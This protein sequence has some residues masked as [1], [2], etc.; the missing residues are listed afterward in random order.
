MS[1]ARAS[2]SGALA[3]PAR[4]A[5]S[6]RRT[7]L[8][9]AAALAL[10]LA[11]TELRRVR[12]GRYDALQLHT[13]GTARSERKGQLS[14]LHAASAQARAPELARRILA[15]PHATMAGDWQYPMRHGC[16]PTAGSAVPHATTHRTFPAGTGR[17]VGYLFVCLLGVRPLPSAAQGPPSGFSRK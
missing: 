6:M 3:R 4:P 17:L 15:A 5:T 2:C 16:A 13:D 12:P 8:R 11:S 1:A 7:C 9:S 14:R 10:A